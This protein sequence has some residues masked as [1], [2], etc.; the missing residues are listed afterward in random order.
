M[1]S[2]IIAF[3]YLAKELHQCSNI[4]SLF[5]VVYVYIQFLKK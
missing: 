2:P 5:Y 4:T 1:D 3:F